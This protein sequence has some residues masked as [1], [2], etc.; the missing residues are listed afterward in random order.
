ML[1]LGCFD[2][3]VSDAQCKAYE[4]E[5]ARLTMLPLSSVSGPDR[6]VRKPAPQAAGNLSVREVQ[7]LLKNAGFFPGGKD[8]GIFGYRT[9]S[10]VRLFQEYVRSVE[11][12]DMVPDGD[13]GPKTQEALKRWRDGNLK[14]QAWLPAIEA[15]RAGAPPAEYVAWLDLLRAAKASALAE[16]QAVH[17]LI[18]GFT[19]PTDTRK[20]A[21]WDYDDPQ[22]MHFIGISRQTAAGL[23]DDV[24][25]LL[26][27]G[28]VFKFQ[29]STEPGATKNPGGPPYLVPGQ[30][31]YRFGWHNGQYLALRPKSAGVLVVRQPTFDGPLATRWSGRAPETV[32]NI[33]I[34][35]GGRGL[36]G[37]VGGW[38]EGCQVIGG[39]IYMAPGG[40]LVDCQG[41]CAIKSTDPGTVPGKTRGA[42]N[43]LVDLVTA[44]GSDL[45]GNTVRYTMLL[46]GDLALSPAVAQELAAAK[47][48]VGT[49]LPGG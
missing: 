20:V 38:S 39:S 33:N 19:K 10:A 4:D 42:Y 28:L 21:D 3:Q 27:K 22:Q 36:Q 44:L 45:P 34:H 18:N 23:S 43:V 2:P 9:L 24:F 13:V 46:E 1:E 32:N 12:Q 40:K 37:K 16:P 47:A 15:W 6:F 5:V 26:I 17:Q 25:V 11:G 31:D 7:Q 41:F 29:G 8:D 14:P 35:W 48:Q 49:M 30:H